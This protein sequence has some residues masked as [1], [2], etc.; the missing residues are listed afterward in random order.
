MLFIMCL[1]NYLCYNFNVM[2]MENNFVTDI[3]ELAKYSFDLDEVPV[4]AVVVKDNLIIGKGYN[5][6]EKDNLITG[7]AELMA[8][9]EACKNIGDWRLDECDLYVTL[10]PCM[11]C[12][13]AIVDARIRNVYYLCDKTNV[14]YNCNDIVFYKIG[15]VDIENKYIKLLKLFFEKKRN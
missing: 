11:M 1:I 7:H 2:Y 9:N 8:I 3:F 12:T 4:G 6:R 14:C 13:G 5:T 10:R 15:N